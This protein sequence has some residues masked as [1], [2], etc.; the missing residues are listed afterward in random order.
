MFPLC[1]Q[2]EVFLAMSLQI[3]NP[4]QLDVA[5]PVL[6]PVTTL[7]GHKAVVNCTLWLPTKKGAL[8]VCYLLFTLIFSVSL[9]SLSVASE[10]KWLARIIRLKQNH[11]LYCCS[12]AELH[13]EAKL[14]Y[15]LET[16]VLMNNWSYLRGVSYRYIA[17]VYIRQKNV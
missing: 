10:L 9:N 5:L 12:C 7:P 15:H 8:K 6:N 4:A 2:S 1:C 3:K 14:E 13:F 17:P 11:V 16:I